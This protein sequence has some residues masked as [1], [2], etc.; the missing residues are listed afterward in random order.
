MLQIIRDISTSD[1]LT[2]VLA[3]GSYWYGRVVL[4]GEDRPTAVSVVIVIVSA[5]EPRLPCAMTG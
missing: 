2:K 1:E 3:K 4:G 5:L